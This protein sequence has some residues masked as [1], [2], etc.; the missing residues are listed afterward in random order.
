MSSAD[1]VAPWNPG[2]GPRGDGVQGGGSAEEETTSVDSIP[3]SLP[4]IQPAEPSVRARRG[5]P[6]VPGA[7]PSAV[8]SY[9]YYES[10]PLRAVE[11]PFTGAIDVPRSDDLFEQQFIA[12]GLPAT[13]HAWSVQNRIDEGA[14]RRVHDVHF[15]RSLPAAELTSRGIHRRR[16]DRLGRPNSGLS[17]AEHACRQE[18]L[19]TLV[20]ALDS[21]PDV[22][23]HFAR[24]S[25]QDFTVY[26]TAILEDYIGQAA[27]QPSHAVFF[28][29]LLPTEQGK[30]DWLDFSPNNF[31]VGPLVAECR[32]TAIRLANESRRRGRIAFGLVVPYSNTVANVLYRGGQPQDGAVHLGNYVRRVTRI[33]PPL[34]Q[35]ALGYSQGSTAILLYCRQRGGGDGLRAAVA[36]APMGGNDGQGATGML[37]GELGQGPDRPGVPT[38]AITHD[39][40]RVAGIY[41]DNVLAGAMSYNFSR[42]TVLNIHDGIHHTG[43]QSCPELGTKGYPLNEIIP[44]ALRLIYEDLG[45]G[46]HHPPIERNWSWEIPD[47]CGG[48]VD[49]L[50]TSRRVDGAISEGAAEEALRL[51]TEHDVPEDE[52]KEELR[53]RLGRLDP[54]QR[55]RLLAALPTATKRTERYRRLVAALGP[56]GLLPYVSRLLSYTLFD[57]KVREYEVIEVRRVLMALP[58]AL[59]EDLLDRLGDKQRA[60]LGRKLLRLPP[61]T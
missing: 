19:A 30:K 1:L 27:A 5:R 59:R 14:L 18:E 50:L 48:T 25:D 31:T 36:L 35:V 29:D 7:S 33:G 58:P 57:W 60:R 15:L 32:Y 42:R 43:N 54:E 45:H 38:L 4:V 13:D 46:P 49:H 55:T 17:P 3:P 34:L 23:A 22:R 53:H 39:Q 9:R 2:P 28:F 10:A 52:D 26:Q 21:S 16:Y 44:L 11:N 12:L 47:F 61:E 40:D 8:G 56:E 41:R 6:V 37:L 51:L 20:R 24:M